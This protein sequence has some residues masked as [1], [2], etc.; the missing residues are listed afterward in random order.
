ML[1]CGFLSH[2]ECPDTSQEVETGAHVYQ[3]GSKQHQL[4]SAQMPWY[5]G[6]V[7]RGE[8]EQLLSD[9]PYDCFLIRQS[10]TQPGAYTISLR[11]E[12]EVKHFLIDRSAGQYEVRGTSHPFP[13]LPF[14]VQHYSEH[15][16]SVGGELLKR[17]CPMRPD[18]VT[19]PLE[20]G[21]KYVHLELVVCI[22][23]IFVVY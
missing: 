8:A 10:Q 23:F 21:L 1:C 13:N 7:S 16:L 9:K 14:L 2:S 4:F 19:V 5:H 6:E 17:A 11:H 15:P 12:G 18:T 20:G 22:C 3:L